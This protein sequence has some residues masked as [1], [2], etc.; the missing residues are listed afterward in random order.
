VSGIAS[1]ERDHL[2]RHG[3]APADLEAVR[4]TCTPLM[5]LLQDTA[6][7]EAELLQVDTEGYD[8]AILRMIDFSRFLPR[9]IKYE[10]K[11]L[12]AN[13][14]ASTLALLHEHGYRTTAEGPDTT[15]WQRGQR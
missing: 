13:E 15:A 8:A 4:V 1:L 12:S 9:L 6:M 5:E 7:L 3:V 11:S 14:H 10:H 2:L